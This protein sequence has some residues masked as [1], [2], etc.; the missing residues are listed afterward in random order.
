MKR[1]IEQGG[2]AI[3]FLRGDEPY[4]A[5]FRA[6]PRPLLALRVVPDRT[7]SR[8]RNNLWLAG[9]GVKRWMMEATK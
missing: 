5:H 6:Q 3:D 4:K 8:L 2:R 1:A 9:R 7:L